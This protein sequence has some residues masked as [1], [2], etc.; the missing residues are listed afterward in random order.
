M[1]ADGAL[2]PWLQRL[3]REVPGLELIDAHTHIGA[4]DPDG[5]RCSGERLVE[6]LE[7]AD[8]RGVVFAMHEPD[9]YSPANDMI[10]AEAA[11]SDG[12]PT[13]SAASTPATALWPR[14]SAAWRLALGASSCI[15]APKAS[16]STTRPCRTC[17]A[18]AHERRLPVMCHAGRGIPALGRHAVQMCE[19]FGHAPDPRARRHLRSAW[20]WRDAREHPN[21]FFDTAWWSPSDVQTLFA[22]VP[23]GQILMA[24]DAPYSTPAFGATMAIRHALQAGLDARQVR[25]GRRADGAPAGRPEPARS[26]TPPGPIRCRATRC[27]TA[28]TRS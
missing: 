4:N 22:L 15:H 27:S 17:A 23:P 24:S 6:A 26:R 14:P 2:R 25:G 19:R 28:S 1:F 5:Y 20:I 9:G 3:R 13:R 11:A 12:R 7:L 8:A 18:L 10:I 16:R 21:L